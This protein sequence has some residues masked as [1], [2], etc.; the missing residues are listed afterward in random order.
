MKSL[1]L[2]RSHT[3][4]KCLGDLLNLSEFNIIRVRPDLT[5]LQNPVKYKNDSLYT[6]EF[7]ENS[8]DNSCLKMTCA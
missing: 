3:E 5:N 8:Y 1:T 7:F 4:K 2:Q 6:E